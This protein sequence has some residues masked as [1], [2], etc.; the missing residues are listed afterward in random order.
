M[1]A[2]HSS[3]GC[4]LRPGDLFGSGTLSGPTP[5]GAGSLLELTNGGRAPLDLPNGET[6]RFLED[7]DEII[8]RGH[9]EAARYAS[10]GFGECRAVVL[11]A[12]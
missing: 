7:G 5:E 4:D 12:T 11:A 1:V 6:R 8:L 10:I 3:N 9:A 2:H